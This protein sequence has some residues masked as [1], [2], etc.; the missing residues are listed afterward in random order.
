MNTVFKIGQRVKTIGGQTGE[1][2]ATHINRLRSET[3]RGWRITT[4][5]TVELEDG[6]SR[7]YN[8]N[9]LTAATLQPFS[10][11]LPGL[12]TDAIE[13]IGDTYNLAPAQ[14]IALAVD[15]LIE[16]LDP[17]HADPKIAE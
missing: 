16:K 14:V 12:T 5:Y 17:D 9:A 10:A 6:S 3:H 4:S 7:E 13:L 11:S 8:E 2:S 1:I 15:L